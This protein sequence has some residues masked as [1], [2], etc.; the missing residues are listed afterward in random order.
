GPVAGLPSEI[1]HSGAL[2]LA[3]APHVPRPLVELPEHG[4]FPA[5]TT[6]HA[7]LLPLVRQA[8]DSRRTGAAPR[9]EVPLAPGGAWPEGFFQ[10][11]ARERL[12]CWLVQAGADPWACDGNGEDAL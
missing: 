10:L 6:L 11:P 8:Q 9:L 7:A 3:L 4:V 2:A 12:A 1:E 5:G